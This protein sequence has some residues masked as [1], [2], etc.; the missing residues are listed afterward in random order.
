MKLVVRVYPLLALCLAMLGCGATEHTISSSS[1][2][3]GGS[4]SGGGGA[5][6]RGGANSG[7]I[8]GGMGGGQGGAAP[9]CGPVL[10][11]AR[12]LSSGWCF[13][14]PTP[15]GVEFKAIDGSLDGASVWAVG[16]RGGAFH[17]C[18]GQWQAVETGSEAALLD[19]WHPSAD[20]ALA[21]GEQGTILQWDGESWSALDSPTEQTL[22]AV[23]GSA[24]DDAWIGG[25]ADADGMLLYHFDGAG[26]TRATLPDALNADTLAVTGR[27]QSDVHA[28]GD[29]HQAFHFDGA[30]WTMSS[31]MD[32]AETSG[33]IAEAVAYEDGSTLALIHGFGYDAIDAYDGAWNPSDIPGDP[34]DDPALQALSRSASGKPWIVEQTLDDP[35]QRL[36]HEFDGALWQATGEDLPVLP[37]AIWSDAN[38]GASWAV[39]AATSLIER[40]NGTWSPVPEVTA[41]PPDPV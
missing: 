38:S 21:V 17:L 11:G 16:S 31:V 12:C 15:E 2:G 37:Q 39:G 20:F 7:G 9:A 23:W 30:S 26:F 13:D 28:V 10:T 33:P 40:S 34:G 14:G 5:G 8:G 35:P 24:P 18:E 25:R 6:G 32:S 1:A 19:V 29:L 4:V 22:F 3:A 41:L 27:G 36:L